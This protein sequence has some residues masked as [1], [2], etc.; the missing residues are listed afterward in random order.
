MQLAYVG[1]YTGAPGAG[2]NGEGIYLFEMNPRTGQLGNRRL[3]AQA[4]SP[5]WIAIH[6]SKKFLYA[7]N[8]VSSFAGRNGSITAYAI[9]EVS[10]ALRLLNRVSSQGAGPA[11]VGLDAIGRFIFV[12]NYG[13]GSLAV[14]S[15]L[16][17]GSLGPALDVR[18][19]TDSIGNIH[20]TD[21]PAG[22]FAVSGH[23]APH[24]HMF[25]ADPANRFALAVDLG[26]DRI[27]SFHV[28]PTSGILSANAINPYVSLPSGD[29]PRHFAFHP[30]G[31]WLY[32]VQEESSTV[33]CF[34]YDPGTGS[35]TAVQTISTL[36]A[37]FTGTSFASEILLSPDGRYLYAANRLHD[38][39]AIFAIGSE[40]RLVYVTETLTRGDYPAQCRIDPAGRFF[41]AC[42]RRS[43][44]ITV[45]RIDRASGLL[46][47]TGQ[48]AAVGSPASITFLT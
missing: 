21:L 35:M 32:T 14:L 31:R 6:P 22:S 37:G 9:D 27:Y 16:T 11:Y 48:Y 40:G 13:D 25:A 2:S 26:Q 43:D 18:H 33:V 44:C 29:G 19:D 41:Y 8:E 5:S 30:N 28:D 7:A 12:A 3:V 42:N 34:H 4:D 17:D 36:P 10:G 20:A 23:D 15:L 39:I 45:F 46:T 1:T 47:F 38:T 24:V